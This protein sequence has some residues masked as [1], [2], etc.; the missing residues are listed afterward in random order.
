MGVREICKV[1]GTKSL[2]RGLKGRGGERK[3]GG[4]KGGVYLDAILFCFLW[5]RWCKGCVGDGYREAVFEVDMIFL[6]GSGVD[7]EIKLVFLLVDCGGDAT[8]R[9]GFRGWALIFLSPR[10]R[11]HDGQ[12]YL[13]S[14]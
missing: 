8:Y 9:S 11:D 1:S 2:L 7:K 13:T 14:K 12:Y 3:G 10:Q 5:G 4:R 6:K